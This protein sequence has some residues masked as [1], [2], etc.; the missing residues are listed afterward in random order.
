M[1]LKSDFEIFIGVVAPLGTERKWFLKTLKEKFSLSNYLTEEI[2]ITDEMIKFTSNDNKALSFEYFVKME[3]CNELRKNYSNGFLMGIVINKIRKLRKNK[4][5]KVVYIIDQIKNVNEYNVLSHVYGLNYIQISLFSNENYRDGNLKVKFKNDCVKSLANYKFEL[6]KVGFYDASMHENISNLFGEISANIHNKF[7]AEILPDVTHNLIKKDFNEIAGDSKLNGQQVSDLFHLSHYF[8]NLDDSKVNIFKEINKFFSLVEGN[9]EDYPTQDEFG[10]SL[11]FQVSVRS[12][13]PNNRHIGASIISPYGEV[14]SVA[15]I[16]AP[17]PTS[18]PTLFDQYQVQDGYMAYKDKITKWKNFL[19]EC[20][21]KFD[22]LDYEEKNTLH[23]IS[24]FLKD[25]LDFHP[26]T[27]AEIAAIIDAAKLGVSVRNSTLYT[28]TFPCHL[29][30]KEIINAGISKVVYLEAYPKS[31]NKELYPKLIDFDPSHPSSLLPFCFYSGVGPKRLMYVYS[32]KNK[33]KH[34][35]P[36]PL[37]AYE[38]S[39]YYERKESDILSYLSPT[40]PKH[41]DFLNSLFK[42]EDDS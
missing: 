20:H 37:I 23:D 36:P 3:I 26:C 16:R 40:K 18:N 9:N 38:R 30:A 13:F 33:N 32:V 22:H 27:H 25:S 24:N 21:K 12:N 19:T 17:C 28:T 1:D 31:K 39:C 29:C 42:R 10:M 5:K 35:K 11:A 7:E 8:F 4:N 41:L 14:I 6:K 34:S 15:S 2:S